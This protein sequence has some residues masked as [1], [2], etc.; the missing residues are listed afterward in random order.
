M[1]RLLAFAALSCVGVSGALLVRPAVA[2]SAASYPLHEAASIGDVNAVDLLLLAGV[3]CEARNGKSSTALHMAAQH[4][5]EAVAR[6]LLEAGACADAENADGLTPLHAAASASQESLARLLLQSGA[7]AD[8]GAGARLA[9]A[10]IAAR[11]GAGGVLSALIS[12]GAHLSEA[13]ADAAFWSAVRMAEGLTEGE[14][15]PTAVAQLLHAVFASDASALAARAASD[16]Q[17]TNLTCLQ[18]VEEGGVAGA[19][20]GLGYLFDDGAH[21]DLPLKEGRRCEGGRCCAACSRALYPSFASDAECDRDTFPGLD[22]FNFNELRWAGVGTTL[23]FVRLVERV[24]RAIA[25]QYGL[26]LGTVLPLQAYARKYVAGQQQT[27]GGGSEGDSVILHT[28]EAT[29]AGYHYSC[30]LYLSSAGVDFEGGRSFAHV[31]NGVLRGVAPGM[32]QVQVAAAAG[33]VL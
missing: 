28:D 19:S 10:G 30:V 27:G 6:R 14:G 25:A 33:V 9:P 5:H 31:Y 3:D 2:P 1:S 8:G 21:A 17:T 12:A 22:G 24:R 20:V 32:D 15:M 26:P 13:D 16:A 7:S 29:H 11:K 4:G 23:H 18:P